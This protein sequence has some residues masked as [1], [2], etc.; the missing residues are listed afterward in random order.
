MSIDHHR[1]RNP[2][3]PS[4]PQSEARESSPP[5]GRRRRRVLCVAN[6]S[7]D[8]ISPA[9]AAPQHEV[10]AGTYAPSPSRESMKST[11]WYPPLS[12][13]ARLARSVSN[14]RDALEGSP[15]SGRQYFEQEYKLRQK[16]RHSQS[17]ASHDTRDSIHRD[18]DNIQ[19]AGRRYSR[20][21][22][23]RIPSPSKS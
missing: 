17:V 21:P 3:R 19:G 8:S 5:R 15:D 6:P 23:V 1:N 10:V 7:P 11:K 4:P 14:R 2:T 12:S 18:C 16:P 20:S 22:S 9:T 13:A